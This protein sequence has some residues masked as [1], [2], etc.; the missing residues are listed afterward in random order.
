MKYKQKNIKLGIVSAIALG[1][2]GLSSASF[3]TETAGTLSVK[4][5]VATSCTISTSELDF[6]TYD[7]AA[8]A[9]KTGTGGSVTYNC[10]NGTAGTVRIA[11]GS[12]VDSTDPGTEASPNRRMVNGGVFLNYELYKTLPSTVW[13][14]TAE[15][16]IILNGTGSDVNVQIHGSIPAGQASTAGAYTDS[17]AI[18]LF[19]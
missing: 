6:G 15:S 10:T 16:G 4:A 2:L 3:A 14:N 18:T 5:S 8:A 19:Y 1:S 11:G 7:T 9:A 17:V 13:G 12:N